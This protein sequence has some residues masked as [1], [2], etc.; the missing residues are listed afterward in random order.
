M[1]SSGR[2]RSVQVL[3]GDDGWWLW[4]LAEEVRVRAFF[5]LPF[6][7]YARNKSVEDEGA[8]RENIP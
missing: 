1:F 8:V 7:W 4:Q 2:R 5:F 6:C 3:S